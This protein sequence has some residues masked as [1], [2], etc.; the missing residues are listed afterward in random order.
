[1]QQ[2][3]SSSS[4][5]HQQ[6]QQQQG[7]GPGGDKGGKDGR[8]GYYNNNNNNYNNYGG[9]GSYNNRR[10][11]GPGTGGNT[12]GRFNNNNNYNN[13]SNMNHRKPLNN[14]T[15]NT[16][17]TST[18]PTAGSVSSVESN[19]TNTNN[20]NNIPVHQT[21]NS[22]T[23]TANAD[24]K[25]GQSSPFT[26]NNQRH[27]QS[28]SPAGKGHHYG[29]N[30]NDTAIVSAV[31][32]NDQQQQQFVGG[33]QPLQLHTTDEGQMYSV[34]GGGGGQEVMMG[35]GQL[36]NQ[37]PSNVGAIPM[38]YFGATSGQQIP[39]SG[40][41][42]HLPPPFGGGSNGGNQAAM[43]NQQQLMS[44]PPM[45]NLQQQQQQQG[46]NA[47]PFY[48]YAT[49]YPVDMVGQG[50]GAAGV[51]PGG[52]LTTAGDSS[53]MTANGNM[54]IQSIPYMAA[55]SVSPYQTA[56]LN[57]HMMGA[58]AVGQQHQVCERGFERNF[59]ILFLIFVFNFFIVGDGDKCPNVLHAD[60]GRGASHARN[61]GGTY[62][63]VLGAGLDGLVV[64]NG[65]DARWEYAVGSVERHWEYRV[66]PAIWRVIGWWGR[67]CWWTGRRSDL[68]E[69]VAG[70]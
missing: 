7:G 62:R 1:M 11:G 60:S 39:F 17:A 45:A 70:L 52:L 61:A 24:E 38:S 23:T 64:D 31:G 26:L 65:S 14:S 49:Y 43:V 32:N 50:V 16:G 5:S 41:P 13:N 46:Y 28:D 48:T 58:A 54:I 33:Q 42:P 27:G 18:T 21:P 66:L 2:S 40:P 22:H 56:P 3:S 68:R 55:P 59:V 47:S 53:A 44:M 8:G 19:R 34:V 15:S 29:N 36:I 25:G 63:G 67:G 9:Y 12:G 37:M 10:N 30:T 57:Q 4:S 6:N 20:T 51:A 69:S 35:G